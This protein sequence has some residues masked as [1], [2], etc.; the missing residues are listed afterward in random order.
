MRRLYIYLIFIMII[1]YVNAELSLEIS[2][3]FPNPTGNDKNEEEFIEIHNY[4]NLS[5][6]LSG[7]RLKNS[8]N[9][10]IE[11]SEF[12]DEISPFEYM[13]FYPDFSLKN[14]DEKIM[15]FYGYELIEEVSYVSTF[16]NFSW[17]KINGDWYL[18]KRSIEMPNFKNIPENKEKCPIINKSE[19][20]AE[21]LLN[22]KNETKKS[23]IYISKDT[24]QR[25]LGGY[26]F[27]LALVFIIITLIFE[28]WKARK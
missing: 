11:L 5:I 23:I 4:G 1:S 14:T 16:E 26:L 20:K 13:V 8:K 17:T 25:K 3:I 27:L 6:S 2:E 24:K 28:K 10:T 19:N 18:G 22:V 7:I 9:K 12:Y 15:L 21:T